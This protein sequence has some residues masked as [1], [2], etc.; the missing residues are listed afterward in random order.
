MNSVAVLIVLLAGAPS[1]AAE[2]PKRAAGIIKTWGEF[3]AN[4]GAGGDA[5]FTKV[6]VVGF[7]T[8][9]RLQPTSTRF[10][11]HRGEINARGVETVSWAT[12]ETCPHVPQILSDVRQL[13]PVLADVTE[14]G[15]NLQA[16]PTPPTIG[17]WVSVNI[18]Q[19]PRGESLPDDTTDF[20]QGRD[21]SGPVSR[22]VEER[23]RALSSCWRKDQPRAP[24]SVK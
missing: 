16:L 1:S 12:S 15:I 24:A 7:W 22:W 9:P 17:S 19:L 20:A 8:G 2:Q 5:G 18:I 4:H 11:L 3:G 10:I 21:A 13:D 14:P 6:T 23:L